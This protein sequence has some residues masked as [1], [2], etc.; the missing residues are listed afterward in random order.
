M[1]AELDTIVLTTDLPRHGLRA[2]DVGTIALV[3]RGGVAYEVEFLTLDGRT[4]AVETLPA[5]MIR[6]A[7]KDEILHVRAMAG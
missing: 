1:L 3:H 5:A 7:A 2:G 6:P 4:V